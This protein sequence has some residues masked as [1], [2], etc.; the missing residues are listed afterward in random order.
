MGYLSKAAH[1]DAEMPILKTLPVNEV[2]QKLSNQIA[3]A[4][5]IGKGC[6]SSEDEDFAAWRGPDQV[7]ADVSGKMSR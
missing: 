1:P 7:A 6:Y 4:L 3:T 5:G 2:S